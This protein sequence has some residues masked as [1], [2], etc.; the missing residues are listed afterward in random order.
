MGLLFDAVSYASAL[1]VVY[2]S[3]LF[4]ISLWTTRRTPAA[5]GRSPWFVLV[6][7]AHNE[8][9]VIGQTV[10]RARE[11]EGNRYSVLIMNDGSSDATSEQ[12]RLAA[13]SDQR[14]LVV[15]RPAAVA[16]QGKGEVLNHA[17]QLACDMARDGDPR[18]QGARAEEVVLCIVDAD[19]WLE[20]HALRVVSPY[21]ADPK[22]AGVQLPVRMWNSRDGFLALMQD[23]EFIG[24]SLFV[25]AGRDPF[26][27]VGLGGNGQFVRLAALQSLGD[28][29][30]SRCLTED[31]DL[32]LSL[33]EH[34]WRNRF[35][36]RACV[37]Q[38]ALNQVRPLLRQ[39]TRWT[40]GHY[41]CWQHLPLLWRARGVALTTRIDLSLYLVLVVF[42]LVLGGQFTAGMLEWA[43]LLNPGTSFLSFV[44]NDHLYRTISLALSLVPV[45][46]FA[47]TYQRFAAQRLPLWALPGCLLLFAVYNYAWGIPASLCALG[48]TALRRGSWRLLTRSWRPRPPRSPTPLKQQHGQDP[49]R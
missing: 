12:A 11:L 30:W 44:H 15:D 22:V 45:L 14:I 4:V 43:G 48:R 8:E 34:G 9:L 40:Q 27:S 7:P 32:S 46:G 17:Y 28:R 20:P 16:G 29:P 38:Q 2:Y 42:V 19:G 23:M 1:I 25:Q 33:V 49:H 18:L 5:S 37:A 24:F 31:L 6:I 3:T 47:V 21:F 26:N 36:P 41:S 10:R 13:E 35:C 39:R